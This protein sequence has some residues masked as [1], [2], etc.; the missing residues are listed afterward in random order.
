MTV[1]RSIRP[2]KI[3]IAM[4]AVSLILVACGEKDVILP[5]ERFAVQPESVAE[6]RVQAVRLAGQ[7]A[8][9]SW[10][11]RGGGAD[12]QITH[13]ALSPGLAPVFAVP[14]GEG[15]SRRARITADPVVENGTIYTLDARAT[16]S[17]TATSGAAVWSRD[18]RPGNDGAKDASGGGL[19][20]GGG[21]L[22]VTTGFGAL[23]ALDAATGAELWTQDL[24]APGGAAPTVFGDLVYLVSRN[25]VA[26][27]LEVETGRIRWQL[28][29]TPS[30]AGF[31]GGAG[32]A[33]TS[34]LAL[35]PFSS[36]EV[37]AAFRKG[38]QQRWRAFVSGERAG[39]AAATIG[40]I[41]GDPVVFGQRVYVGNVAGR[42]AALDLATGDRAWTAL[43]GAVS[44]VW[45]TAD[46]VYLLNDLNQ[47]VRLDAAS[48]APV[49]R[50]DLPLSA[51]VRRLAQRRQVYAHY[52]PILAGGR[53]IVASSDGQL[54]EFD[55]RSGALI[56]TTE[57]PG[58]AATNPVVA[59]GTLYVVTKDG[60]LRAFR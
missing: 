3:T 34:E 37:I 4:A 55:P 29:G 8:N 36:G 9:A 26:W 6:N 45:P 58:G 11:H 47:L 41:A 28:S 39:S 1:V 44:P 13:P 51:P 20:V 31:D 10:T 19:A 53:L 57:L 30:S 22:F 14:I 2:I 59:G 49:W 7:V 60:A 15:D 27:A 50:V 33:V 38:G 18:L 35:F 40:D 16:V 5:G 17:A 48:G 32:P 54:R 25:G 42:V 52:G 24:D 23:T 56:A 21:R 12:H 43:E 46:S